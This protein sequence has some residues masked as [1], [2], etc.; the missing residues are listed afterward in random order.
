MWLY[1]S[2]LEDVEVVTQVVAVFKREPEWKESLVEWMAKLRSSFAVF[3][4]PVSCRLICLLGRR[5]WC[6]EIY[7]NVTF[8][9]LLTSAMLIS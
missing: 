9:L 1:T 3:L 4:N 6:Q 7:I 5:K 8:W 2:T